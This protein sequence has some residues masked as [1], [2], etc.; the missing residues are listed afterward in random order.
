LWL[1]A[2]STTPITVCLVEL[3]SS[4]DMITV[5]FALIPYKLT[6]AIHR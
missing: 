6:D 5:L 2:S 4:T 1:S 3:R